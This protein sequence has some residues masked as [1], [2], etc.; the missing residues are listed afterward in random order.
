MQHHHSPRAGMMRVSSHVMGGHAH[1]GR[2][3]YA[4]HVHAHGARD[5]RGL[6]GIA[7]RHAH[8]FK[9]LWSWMDPPSSIFRPVNDD[10]SG[11]IQRF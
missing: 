1:V 4:R 7:E 6:R 3:T 2:H 8:T 11:I 10:E 9:G 5:A